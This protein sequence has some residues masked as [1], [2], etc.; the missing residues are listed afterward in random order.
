MTLHL[1]PAGLLPSSNMPVE[2]SS[3]Q[4]VLWMAVVTAGNEQV[5]CATA[6]NQIKIPRLW[7]YPMGCFTAAMQSKPTLQYLHWQSHPCMPSACCTECYA[8]DGT[9]LRDVCSVSR[10]HGALTWGPT[11]RHVGAST[12]PN[13]LMIIGYIVCNACK[14]PQDLQHDG[15]RLP[16]NT[17]HS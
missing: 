15:V 17:A 1:I 5:R 6:V 11:R 13:V 2:S 3:V 4:G 12:E 8:I 10:S 14:V 9:I 16:P 7:C